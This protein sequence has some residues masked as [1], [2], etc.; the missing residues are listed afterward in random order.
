ME[1]KTKVALI[2]L[3]CIIL[4]AAILIVVFYKPGERNYAKDYILSELGGEIANCTIEED[5]HICHV[6]YYEE[7]RKVADI[8][9]Y[10]YPEG[11][12]PY[13]EY[14]FVGGADQMISS[15]NVVILLKGDLTIRREACALYNEKYGFNCKA[16]K[17]P[18]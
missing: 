2:I 10:Y 17:E 15:D 1:R 7:N 5:V 3:L 11:I 8:W 18:E 4:A 13:K 9:I 12:E 14:T 16:F 6:V